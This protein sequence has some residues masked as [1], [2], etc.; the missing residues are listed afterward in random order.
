MSIRKIKL[1][2]QNPPLQEK[3]TNNKINLYKKNFKLI[4]PQH[5]YEKIKEFDQ[6]FIIQNNFPF[7]K[8]TKKDDFEPEVR[9]EAGARNIEF[10]EE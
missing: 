7:K 9:E 3:R 5:R 2:L 10:T 4:I 1:C 6:T 8:T